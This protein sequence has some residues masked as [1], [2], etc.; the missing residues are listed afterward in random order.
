MVFKNIDSASLRNAEDNLY[1]HLYAAREIFNT[2]L[3]GDALPLCVITLQRKNRSY[4][5]FAAQRLPYSLCTA[6]ISMIAEAAMCLIE[7][8]PDLAGGIYTPA[9]AMGDKL[10]KRLVEHGGL[11]FNLES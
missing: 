9:P 8:C 3:F 5:Y 11:T 7:D 6:R 4:G 2:E 1:E 10:I